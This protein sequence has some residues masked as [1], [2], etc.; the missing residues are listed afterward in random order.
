MAYTDFQL[1]AHFS[2][3]EMIASDTAAAAAIN[4]YPP[5]DQLF[6]ELRRTCELLELVRALL[7]QPIII[8]SGFRCEDLNREVGGSENSQHK[9][10][11]AADF[12]CGAYTPREIC[13]KIV[14]NGQ[15]PFDQ[16]ILEYD[17]WCHI[18]QAGIGNKGRQDVL[19]IDN[20]GTRAGIG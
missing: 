17:E 9:I 4:N 15:I 12:T 3:S 1:T 16:L 18:S 2:L 20:N 10:G 19:T 7:G 11:Q 14:D 5:D 13:Q 8:T 6:V